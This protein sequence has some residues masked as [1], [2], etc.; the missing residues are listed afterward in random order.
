MSFGPQVDSWKRQLILMRQ[1]PMVL[2]NIGL[3]VGFKVN[4]P[5]F[6]PIYQKES[7]FVFCYHLFPSPI[8]FGA[9]RKES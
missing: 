9:M 5:S 2:L 6:D 7:K 4:A 3:L 8:R 1:S